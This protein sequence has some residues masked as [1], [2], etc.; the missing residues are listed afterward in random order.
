LFDTLGTNYPARFGTDDLLA[1]N[2]LDEPV[3][4]YQIECVMSGALMT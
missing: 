3:N 1:L 2:L 4:A